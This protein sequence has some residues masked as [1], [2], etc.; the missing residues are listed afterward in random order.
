MEER[1]QILLPGYSRTEPPVK[2]T[3]DNKSVVEKVKTDEE[4]GWRGCVGV[5]CIRVVVGVVVNESCV[6]V[7][8]GIRV[9]RRGGMSD[10]RKCH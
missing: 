5:G 7:K 9:R 10:S 2:R 8:D 1:V 4:R 6:P 3:G